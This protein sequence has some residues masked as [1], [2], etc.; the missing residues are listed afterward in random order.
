MVSFDVSW[1][2]NRYFITQVAGSVLHYAHELMSH[3]S[4][5]ML[6]NINFSQYMYHMD[7]LYSPNPIAIT[8]LQFTQ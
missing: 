7:T 2:Y 6:I 4:R 8:V 1:H 5:I 3:Y